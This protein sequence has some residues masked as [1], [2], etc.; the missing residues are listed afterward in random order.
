[1]ESML[2]GTPESGMLRMLR[3]MAVPLLRC[4]KVGDAQD[5]Y[6][7]MEGMAW[8]D[9]VPHHRRLVILDNTADGRLV[10]VEEMYNA[11]VPLH[12]HPEGELMVIT[13]SGVLHIYQVSPE[14]TLIHHELMPRVGS[15]NMV[16]FNTPPGA[17]HYLVASGYIAMARCAVTGEVVE[18][19]W[20][21]APEMYMLYPF[22]LRSS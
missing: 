13:G 11:L 4:R 15:A 21:P 1:M 10:T 9:V 7:I 22:L 16:G 17:K 14:G 5:K 18:P 20:R 2:G 6:R 12:D 8:E 3:E 19:N